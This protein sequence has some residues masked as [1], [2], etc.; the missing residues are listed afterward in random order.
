MKSVFFEHF[1]IVTAENLKN[2]RDQNLRDETNKNAQNPPLGR[3]LCSL[4]KFVEKL[5]NNNLHN[6]FFSHTFFPL[7]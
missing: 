2:Q 6:F 5:H 3:K 4:C 1:L 7:S